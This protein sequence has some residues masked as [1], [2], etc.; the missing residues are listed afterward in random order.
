MVNSP[1]D[2][3]ARNQRRPRFFVAGVYALG[4]LVEFAADDARK[5]IVVLR[6]RAGDAVEII[7]SS[8]RAYASE[9]VDDGKGIRARLLAE[10]APLPAAALRIALAQGFPKGAKMDFVVE[11]A[12]ELGVVR[13]LPFTSERTVAGPPHTGKRARWERLATSAAQQCGR[14]DVPVIEE[15]AAFA[16]VCA[17]FHEFDLALVPW[18]LARGISLRECLPP[19][20]ST[21][22]TVL[23]VI[24]PEGGLSAREAAAAEAAGGRTVSLGARI[25]RT[26][27]AALVVCSALLYASGDL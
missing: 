21:A 5:L 27:T 3:T 8:G 6:A 18:E 25:L 10:N 16:D 1:P 22:Q 23:V 14:T 9:I 7:D 15:T 19:L 17:R 13:M 11:K 26:E 4:E 24:G 2:S 12:T 20:L